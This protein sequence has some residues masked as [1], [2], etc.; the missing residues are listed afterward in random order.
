M[1]EV[2]MLDWNLVVTTHE[3][4]YRD[5]KELLAPMGVLHHTDYYNVLVM[6]VEAPQS[7]LATLESLLKKNPQLATSLARVLPVTKTFSYQSPQEFELEAA[8]AAGDCLAQLAGR[9]FHVRMH[10][11]GF[12][13]R[14]SS[15][16]EEQWLADWLIDELAKQ[17]KTASV[18]FADPDWILA[19]DTVGQ[20]AG[21]SLWSREQLQRYPLLK[22]D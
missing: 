7:F 18:D 5:A 11:R 4:R 14:L 20:Q 21:L 3:H 17:G 9:R 13:G 22:L 12:K 15:Q 10:R 16:Q 6:R 2:K 19:I 8:S 1:G